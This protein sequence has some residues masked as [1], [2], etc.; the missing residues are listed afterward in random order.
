M[1]QSAR[2]SL[3][4]IWWLLRERYFMTCF[5]INTENR[6]SLIEDTTSYESMRIIILASIEL[7]EETARIVV[8]NRR[9][10]VVI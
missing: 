2:F 7:N 9:A 1:V 10:I 3:R 6:I 5:I 4:Q 8:V